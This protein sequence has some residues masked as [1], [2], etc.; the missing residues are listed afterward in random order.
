MIEFSLTTEQKRQSL[1]GVANNLEMDI[2]HLILALGE[3]PDSYDFSRVS[4]FADFPAPSN[5]QRLF[6]LYSRYNLIKEKISN[7]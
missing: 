5:E 3:D 4:E 2:Y 7:L 1:Q 6:S